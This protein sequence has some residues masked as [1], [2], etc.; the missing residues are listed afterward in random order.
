[1]HGPY[2]ILVEFV[3]NHALKFVFSSDIEREP[4]HSTS[5]V[6]HYTYSQAIV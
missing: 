4:V 1:M 2:N 6:N 3:N 5:V